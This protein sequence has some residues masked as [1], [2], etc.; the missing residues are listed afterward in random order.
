MNGGGYKLN[1]YNVNGVV[2]NVTDRYQIMQ[3]VGRGAYGLV[4][5]A[6][7]ISE[8][9]AIRSAKDI[10]TG[11][12]VAIKKIVNVFGNPRDTKR[13]LREIKLLRHFKHEN[14][15]HEVLHF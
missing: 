7:W 14:V 6:L 1:S 12:E 8:S 11:E 5:Y 13:T 10:L 4:V 3:P 9:Y 15:S 2:F